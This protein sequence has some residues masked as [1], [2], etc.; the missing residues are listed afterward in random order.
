MNAILSLS[1]PILMCKWMC[2]N[3]TLLILIP[4]NAMPT[5]KHFWNLQYGHLKP[6]AD[7]MLQHFFPKHLGNLLLSIHLLK[8]AWKDTL[9]T[10]W[11]PTV[12]FWSP[13][14]YRIIFAICIRRKQ[15]DYNKVRLTSE[16]AQLSVFRSGMGIGVI[17]VWAKRNGMHFHYLKCIVVWVWDRSVRI[18][19][20]WADPNSYHYTF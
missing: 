3:F 19:S 7:F 16:S 14:I 2:K 1:Y 15:N 5:D 18:D 6:S 10:L 8:N 20:T 13:T 12:L 9:V 17:M 11:S 4:A